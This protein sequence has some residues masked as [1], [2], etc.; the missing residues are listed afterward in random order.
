MS[1]AESSSLSRHVVPVTKAS[2]TET[3]TAP[4]AASFSQL[5]CTDP[6]CDRSLA[7]HVAAHDPQADQRVLEQLA[8]WCEQFSPLV[9]FEQLDLFPGPSTA[10]RPDCLY[11]D[12]TNLA[13]YF[14]DERTLARRVTESFVERGYHVRVASAQTLGAAWALAHYAVQAAESLGTSSTQRDA[15]PTSPASSFLVVPSGATSAALQSLPIEAL[16]LPDETV[17]LLQQ[18]G[19]ERI[20]Q[21]AC[22][23]RTSLLS[24]FGNTLLRR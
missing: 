20:G 22:L 16:R 4:V 17:S 21:L 8:Q 18:L 5:A 9:G 2:G 13:G 3:V 23:P 14:G 19:I 15:P 12:V 1:L 11:L 7:P 6:L 24:R 10:C